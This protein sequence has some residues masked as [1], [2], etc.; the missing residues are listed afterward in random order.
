MAATTYKVQ[1]RVTK[2]VNVEV[3]GQGEED[4]MRQAERLAS[5]PDGDG[6]Y[7]RKVEAVKVLFIAKQDHPAMTVPTEWEIYS[8]MKGADKV[9][10]IITEKVTKV[11][12]E[13]VVLAKAQDL[14]KGKVVALVVKHIQPVFKRYDEYG[15]SDSEPGDKVAMFLAKWCSKLGAGLDED[16]LADA[17]DMALYF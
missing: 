4:A 8:S 1:V 9:N 6:G 14:S 7:D 11:A 5:W 12:E 16:S 10:S 13:C 15:T 2:L 17:I 3:K